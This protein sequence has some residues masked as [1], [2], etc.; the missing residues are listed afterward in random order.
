MRVLVTGAGGQL[1]RDVVLSC[2]A[3]GD[4]VVG[5]DRSTVDITDR[6]AVM[7]AVT[8]VR[9]DAVINCAAWTAV[10]AC[11]DDPDRALAAN[12]LAV[13]HVVEACHR[14]GAHLVHVSTDYVFDGTL[15][16]PYHEWDDTNPQSVYGMTKLLGEREALAYGPAAAAVR[17]S[18]VCGEHGNNMVKTVLRLVDS[19]PQLSFVAD[20]VGHPTF[21]AD[22]APV[23]RQVALDRRSGVMHLTNQTPTSWY[24][25]VCEVVRLTGRDPE[26]IVRPISTAELH[27]P[28]PAPRPANSVLDNAVARMTGMPPMR[29]FREPMA[30]LVAKLLA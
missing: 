7:A 1:G 13:R 29:D 19:H 18:W 21:T 8:S 17:T 11:E 4:T 20:Q 6:D 24:G 3:A 14:V 16:R 27:P 15:D 10:D 23:L 26:A 25:F 28:R 12:A 2:E 9:P 22:L 30:E 5:V